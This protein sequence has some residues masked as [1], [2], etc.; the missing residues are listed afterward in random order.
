MLLSRRLA[1]WWW[2][3]IKE[4][5]RERGGKWLRRG[6]SVMWVIF[7]LERCLLHNGCITPRHKLCATWNNLLQTWWRTTTTSGCCSP[8][9]W[10]KATIISMVRGVRRVER[11]WFVYVDFF[12]PNHTDSLSLLTHKANGKP[13]AS[14]CFVRH[15]ACGNFIIITT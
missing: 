14:E 5:E 8:V 15:K 4:R 12:S 6:R 13:G 9:W 11:K 3:S 2:R 7:H 1:N 10:W